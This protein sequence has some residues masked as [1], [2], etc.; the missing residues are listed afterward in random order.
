MGYERGTETEAVTVQV[1]SGRAWDGT[2]ST[3]AHG[4][5]GASHMDGTGAVAGDPWGPTF[6]DPAEKKALLDKIAEKGASSHDL[7]VRIGMH[8]QPPTP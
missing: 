8:T 2:L 5:T 1:G 4:S 6:A 7:P 3:A